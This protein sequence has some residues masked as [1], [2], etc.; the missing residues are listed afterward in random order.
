MFFYANNSCS[1]SIN[2]IDRIRTYI[3]KDTNLQSAA[4]TTLPQSLYVWR[5]LCIYSAKKSLILSRFYQIPFIDFVHTKLR[6]FIQHFIY[7]IV[8][9]EI[10]HKNVHHFRKV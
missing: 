2:G 9:Y 10:L 3:V 5:R 8:I 1:K 4:I 7:D 6:P